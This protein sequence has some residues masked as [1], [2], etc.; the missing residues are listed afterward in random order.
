MSRSLS[1]TSFAASLRHA[2][3][4]CRCRDQMAVEGAARESATSA[5]GGRPFAFP[6]TTRKYERDR[7][8]RIEHIA[9]DLELDVPKKSVSGIATLRLQRVDAEATTLKLDAVGFTLETIEIRVA[10]KS[11]LARFTY[12]DETL[13]IE[14]PRAA[15]AFE[16]IITYR[17]TP[18]RG[19]YFL[20]PD[21]HVRDRPRQLW[22]QCQDEDARYWIPCH[23]KPH[24]KQ[25]TELRVRVPKGWFAL[26][27]GVL[28]ERVDEETTSI[29]HWKQD[30]PH[31]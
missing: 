8:F 1:G 21:P 30:K 18:K 22:S 14:I 28:T 19:L 25:T 29:F 4:Q 6:G 26:S 31:S 16:L 24:V 20:E 9:I 15:D 12:D 5:P 23:D 10:K 2:A 3:G 11:T 7:P 13:S 17:V 27:N